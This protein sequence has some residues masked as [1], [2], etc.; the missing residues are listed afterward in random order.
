MLIYQQKQWYT[1][2]SMKKYVY[3]TV[4]IFF[5]LQGLYVAYRFM[6]IF[7]RILGTFDYSPYQIY[8]YIAYIGTAIL[9]V[10]GGLGLFN[11]KKWSVICTWV[12]TLLPQLLR[13][14]EPSSNVPLEHNYIVFCD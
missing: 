8:A 6:A 9:F 3:N 13:L 11:G 14:I 1:N 10:S 12:A 5:I 4:A 7:P 2:N